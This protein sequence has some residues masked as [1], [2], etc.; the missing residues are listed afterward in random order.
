MN[1]IWTILLSLLW[2]VIQQIAHFQTGSVLLTYLSAN[3]SQL[4]V[5]PAGATSQT[6]DGG[7]WTSCAKAVKHSASVCLMYFCKVF[8]HI[9]AAVASQAEHLCRVC[10][11][12]SEVEPHFAACASLHHMVIHW[13]GYKTKLQHVCDGKDRPRPPPVSSLSI[14]QSWIMSPR[15]LFNTGAWYPSLLFTS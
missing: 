5:W 6:W 15:S 13:V 8:R 11:N 4:H 9:T 3:G 14:P 2:K 7:G 12:S 10:I 1:W